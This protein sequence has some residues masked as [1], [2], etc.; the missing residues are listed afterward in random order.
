MIGQTDLDSIE[1]SDGEVYFIICF[2]IH[3]GEVITSRVSPRK[4]NNGVNFYAGEF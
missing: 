1:E 2:F 3:F 4:Q